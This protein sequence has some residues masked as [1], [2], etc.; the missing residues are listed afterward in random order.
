VDQG[1]F[2]LHMPGVH[3][4]LNALAMMAVCDAQKVPVDVTREALASFDGVQRRFTVRGTVDDVIVVDDYGHHPTEIQATLVGAR[5]AFA[6]RRLVA[7]VQPHRYTRVRDNLHA[8]AACLDDA[9]VVVLTEIYAAG[10]SPIDGI[11]AERLTGLVRERRAGRQVV[12]ESDF[13]RL[14]ERIAQ[15]TVPGDLVMTLGAGSITRV[16]S[17]LVE[18]LTGAG[19]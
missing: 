16:G 19:R 5:A 2:V 1:E 9:D 15:L 10:E 12:L 13:E 17:A 8:F 7:V 14:P 18:R 11:T 3:N 4:I 6:D